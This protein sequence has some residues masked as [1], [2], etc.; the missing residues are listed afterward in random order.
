MSI[1]PDFPSKREI[2]YS[3]LV[4]LLMFAGVRQTVL[5]SPEVLRFLETSGSPPLAGLKAIKRASDVF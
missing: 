4:T 3:R 5:K 1:P 2:D